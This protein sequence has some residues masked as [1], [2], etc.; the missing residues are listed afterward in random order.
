ME[1][2]K[3]L[4][5]FQE[6]FKTNKNQEDLEIKEKSVVKYQNNDT[7]IFVF[8]YIFVFSLKNEVGGH[9]YFKYTSLFPAP[10]L[11]LGH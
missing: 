10:K 3:A 8:T 7:K 1:Q 2:H 4:E 5:T 11:L 6:I 9:V